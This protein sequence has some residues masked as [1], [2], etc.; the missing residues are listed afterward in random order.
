MASAW[1][2]RRTSAIIIQ[3]EARSSEGLGRRHRKELFTFKGHE[4]SIGYLAFS[5]DGKKLAG[6]AYDSTA[7]I[8]DLQSGR[9]L[10]SLG[11]KSTD[12]QTNFQTGL[13]PGQQ[14]PGGCRKGLGCGNRPGTRESQ[15]SCR[16]GHPCLQS[17][18]QARGWGHKWRRIGCPD[19]RST[20]HHS[21]GDS[22][23]GWPWLTFSPDGKRLAGS[24]GIW[25]AQT[26]QELLSFGE[27]RS[28]GSGQVTFSPDGHRLAVVPFLAT[29]SPSTTPRRCRRSPKAHPTSV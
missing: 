18:W 7:K 15:G 5:P 14:A 17:R 27:S 22:R 6:T 3:R 10:H 29:K 24:A 19:R 9:E 21:R 4:S 13:Q 11:T 20:L 8:W 12:V 1:P 16:T 28:P 25:D 23:M 26:G 2:Q